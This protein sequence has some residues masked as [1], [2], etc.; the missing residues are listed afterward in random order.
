MVFSFIH[1]SDLH[2]GRG[3]VNIPEP[4]DGNI[5]GRLMEARH[6]SIGRLAGSARDHGAGHVLLAGDTFHSAT[7]SA[8]VIRHSVQ[9][10]V[11]QSD[12]TWWVLPGNHDNLKEAEQLWDTIEGGTP[13]NVKVLRE[14][15]PVELAPGVVLLPC[16]IRVRAGGRDP[17]EE[18][19]GM[20]TADGIVRIGLAH[21]G[22]KDFTDSGN[23]IPPDRDKRSGLDYLALG[24]WHGRL[25]VS[26]RTYYSGSPEQDRFKHKGPGVCLA[27]KIESAGVPPVVADIKTGSMLWAVEDLQLHDKTDA[28]EALAAVLPASGRRDT[29]MRLR[30]SGWAGLQDQVDLKEACGSV[31][32]D[33]AHFEVD[34]SAL[35][36]TYEAADLDEIDRGGALRMA[37]DRLMADAE[38]E[39]LGQIDREVSAAALAR[40]YSYVKE[41]GQ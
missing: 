15:K 21:G 41:A 10:M 32:P 35:R 37:A 9:A 27:V 14:A 18:I 26:K 22:V 2:L 28:K 7:P 25:E 19:E 36:T 31:A 34:L 20:Q 1:S 12:L 16:P 38:L 33:F 17:S 8:A 29:M 13:G 5:R 4:S 30:V 6:D 40:L 23:Q 24:D 3:F 11:E 39:D